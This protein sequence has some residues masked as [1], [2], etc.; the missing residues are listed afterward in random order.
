MRRRHVSLSIFIEY[1][2]TLS[3]VKRAHTKTLAEINRER[4]KGLLKPWR[5]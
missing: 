4:R 2:V 1:G 5:P 3:Q